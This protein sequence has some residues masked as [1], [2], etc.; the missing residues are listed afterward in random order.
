MET[1]VKNRSPFFR[2]SS[3]QRKGKQ[4]C[5]KSSMTSKWAWGVCLTDYLL[6]TREASDYKS[7]VKN[8][9]ERKNEMKMY[10]NE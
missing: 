6:K 4:F 8:E 7:Y 2:M 10:S 5:K 3:P 9:A 1:D